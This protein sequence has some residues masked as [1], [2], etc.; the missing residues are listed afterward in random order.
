MCSPSVHLRSGWVCF[1]IRF[2]EMC[3][4]ISVSAMEVNG[5]RQNESL[6]QT[7]QVIHSTPVHQLTSGEDKRWDK[8][9]IKTFLTQ[10]WVHNTLAPVKAFWRHPFTA[11]M[12]CYISPNLTKKQTQLH[13][14]WPEDEDI[15]FWVNYSFKDYQAPKIKIIIIIKNSKMFSSSEVIWIALKLFH[16]WDKQEPCSTIFC[17]VLLLAKL[18]ICKNICCHINW[19]AWCHHP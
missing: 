6:I 15:H 11:V 12:K 19:L 7:S 16:L 2:V 8:S 3:L 14:G 13:L 5:C 4:C 17:A 1:F 9:N 10:I 18:K